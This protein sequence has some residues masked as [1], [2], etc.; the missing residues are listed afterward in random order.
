MRFGV[1]EKLSPRYVG[2]FEILERIEV[3]AYQ[4]ALPSS[5]SGIHDVFHVSMLK[6]YIPNE[7]H[8]IELMPSQLQED[9]SYDE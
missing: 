1:H 9:L 2:P 6:K 8:V 5:L 3:V 7:R 4:L